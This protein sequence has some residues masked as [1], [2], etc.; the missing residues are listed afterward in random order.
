MIE[1]RLLRT[2]QTHHDGYHLLL[3]LRIQHALAVMI[4]VVG[5]CSIAEIVLHTLTSYSTK[6]TWQISVKT[7]EAPCHPHWHTLTIH[8]TLSVA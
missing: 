3:L 2:A 1:E 4:T 8:F 5:T 7:A 6:M